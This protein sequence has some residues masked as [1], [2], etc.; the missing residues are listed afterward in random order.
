MK[1][2]TS[3]ILACQNA[4]YVTKGSVANNLPEKCV[5][6]AH[7]TQAKLVLLNNAMMKPGCLAD[8]T[9]SN[10]CRKHLSCEIARR[11][12]ELF[13][14]IGFR[15]GFHWHSFGIRLGM[16]GPIISNGFRR[17]REAG[18]PRDSILLLLKTLTID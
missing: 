2:I 6:L 8:A 16:G 14:D 1:Y 9:I 15:F 11:L 7:K 13:L 12:V 4:L 3:Y 18:W 17:R 10:K 5:I